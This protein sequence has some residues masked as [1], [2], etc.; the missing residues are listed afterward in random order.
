MDALI[1]TSHAQFLSWFYSSLQINRLRRTKENKEAAFN[2]ELLIIR[3]PLDFKTVAESFSGKG[4]YKFK[5]W[6]PYRLYFSCSI[7]ALVKGPWKV[8]STVSVV[9]FQGGSIYKHVTIQI[10]TKPLIWWLLFWR[11]SGVEISKGA[12]QR[13]WHRF[14]KRCWSLLKRKT[15]FQSSNVSATQKGEKTG[16]GQ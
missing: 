6:A 1:L 8:D 14:G 3:A 16:E 2:G 10:W 9:L 13:A 12:K 11:N 15:E 7:L 4:W 5:C